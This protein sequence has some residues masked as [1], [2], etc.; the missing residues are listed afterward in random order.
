MGINKI[1]NIAGK[2]SFGIGVAMDIRGM[3]IYKDNPS[4]IFP[5]NRSI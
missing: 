5:E 2:A 1:G 3:L 4:V